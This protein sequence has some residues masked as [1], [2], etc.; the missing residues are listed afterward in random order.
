MKL[1]IS[2]NKFFLKPEWTIWVA[3]TQQFP[4]ITAGTFF[5]RTMVLTVIA[6]FTTSSAQERTIC[7]DGLL[8]GIDIDFGFESLQGA[9]IQPDQT[10]AGSIQVSDQRNDQRDSDR[11]KNQCQP[12]AR[13]ER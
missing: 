11:K 8:C 7:C 9:L 4:G 3:Q 1:Q 10:T 12:K 5:E 2:K 13:C 6:L